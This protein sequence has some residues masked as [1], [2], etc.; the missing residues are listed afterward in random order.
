MPASKSQSSFIPESDSLTSPDGGGRRSRGGNALVLVSLGLLIVTVLAAAGLFIYKNSLST[1]LSDRQQELEDRRSAFDP[2]LIDELDKTATRVETAQSLVDNHLAFTPIFSIVE[3]ATLT[4]VQFS[5][6]E[7]TYND[8]SGTNP[9]NSNSQ[10]NGG[11]TVTLT[12]VGPGYATIAL[13]S[14]ELADH[15]KIRNPI[16][17]DFTLNDEG[18]VEFSVEF[19]VPESEV[20]YKNTI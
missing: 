16:L 12:G 9:G 11:V 3:S 19:M 18:D 8:S 13:Q 1:T 4:S 7:V 5:S 10:P 2:A 17:S 14:S 20:L 15:D 6:M